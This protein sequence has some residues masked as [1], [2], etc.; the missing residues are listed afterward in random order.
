[1]RIV[2]ILQPVW[3]PLVVGVVIICGGFAVWRVHSLFG[4]EKR[5]SYA[6]AQVGNVMYF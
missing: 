1:M 5:P 2:R 4:A 3:I 6:D